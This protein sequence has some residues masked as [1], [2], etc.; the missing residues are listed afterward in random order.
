MKKVKELHIYI[1]EA[2]NFE[3]N[4]EGG[5]RFYAIAFIYIENNLSIKKF[6]EI[7]KSLKKIDSSIAV[8]HSSPLIRQKDIYSKTPLNSRRT[9]FNKFIEFIKKLDI[10]YSVLIIDKN[11]AKESEKLKREIKNKYLNIIKNNYA[12]LSKYTDVILHYDNGQ[13]ELSK[14]IKTIFKDN[15]KNVEF[16][17]NEIMQNQIIIQV[18]DVI[19]TLFTTY[20]K[21]K[22]SK[23][24]YNEREFFG[25]FRNFKKNYIKHISDNL[26]K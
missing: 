10:K 26:L 6:N 14:I 21:Y 11:N 3:F 2:G 23:T 4:S 9:I 5:S 22:Y 18:A 25:S 1:D 19:A 17:F 12:Y 8:M 7:I 20:Q 13:K 15:F 16:L 24:T